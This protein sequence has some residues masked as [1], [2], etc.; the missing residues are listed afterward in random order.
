MEGKKEK[1]GTK[2]EKDGLIFSGF[3]SFFSSKKKLK[4]INL[5]LF[6]FIKQKLLSLNPTKTRKKRSNK[7]SSVRKKP[8]NY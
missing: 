3:V 8:L 6:Y 5:D 4:S 1:D 2:I 7:I